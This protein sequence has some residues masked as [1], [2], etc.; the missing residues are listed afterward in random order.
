VEAADIRDF[1]TTDDISRVPQDH[2]SRYASYPSSGPS[3]RS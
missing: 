1:V 3:D 2:V